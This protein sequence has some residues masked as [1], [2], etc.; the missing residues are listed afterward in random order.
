MSEELD[1]VHITSEGVASFELTPPH[2]PRE[3]TGNYRKAHHYLVDTLQKPCQVCGVTNAFLAD[4]E[5]NVYHATAMETHHYP[6]ERSLMDAC[7]PDKVH[8]Q[9]PQVYDKATLEA[10]IDTP[11]NLIVLCDV[12]HRSMEQGIHHL[13]TQDFAI[14]PFLYDGYQVVANAKDKDAFV[15][16]DNAIEKKYGE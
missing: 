15:T 9:F 14:L 10:F 16:L 7:D 1:A 6:I 12:H 8:K 2:A 5:K 13:L 11:A 4:A 3:E